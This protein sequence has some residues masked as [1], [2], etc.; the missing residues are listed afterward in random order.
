MKTHE[1]TMTG[2]KTCTKCN[3]ELPVICFAVHKRSKD[4]LHYH[5]RECNLS[6]ENKRKGYRSDRRGIGEKQINLMKLKHF[7]DYE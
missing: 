2:T 6:D 1:P 4:G 5:C 3:R 7:L